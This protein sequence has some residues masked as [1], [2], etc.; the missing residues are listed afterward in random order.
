MDPK[1]TGVHTFT[2]RCSQTVH[3]TVA[4]RYKDYVRSCTE[5][6]DT[7]RSDWFRGKKF[8][9]ET[10]SSRW[11]L[12]RE[13]AADWLSSVFHTF[14]AALVSWTLVAFLEPKFA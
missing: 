8:A 12:I 2:Y 7:S 11:L 4:G 9:R 1:H 14:G 10:M 5:A 6:D 13:V 3:I